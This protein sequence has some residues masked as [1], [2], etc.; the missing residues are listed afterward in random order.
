MKSHLVHRDAPDS[1]LTRT[2]WC[3]M[4]P[5]ELRIRVTE[6]AYLRSYA[7]GDHVARK[8]EPCA[9]WLGVLDGLLKV[10][11]VMKNGKSVMF[12]GVP[13]G[14]WVGEG[15]IIK[16]ELRRYD[17]VA[18]RETRVVHLP[19]A[20]FRWLLDTSIEFNRFIMCHLNER[21]GQY[22][23]MVEMA[24]EDRPMFRIARALV[25]LTN[26]I[27]YPNMGPIIPISQEEFGELA[28]LSRQTANG[29]IQELERAGFLSKAYGGVL[30]RDMQGLL[31]LCEEA[32]G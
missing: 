10:R 5:E 15:S 2:P 27:L 14:S 1:F 13:T 26:P 8:G 32:D 6:E 19:A 29:A 9:S 3:S 7:R 11:A 31:R 17:V 24:R 28:G 30:V 25:S 20:T 4:L 18:M 22:I 12:T 16:R 23:G 21:L